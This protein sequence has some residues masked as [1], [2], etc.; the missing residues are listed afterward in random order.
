M[1]QD[2]DQRPATSHSAAPPA[3]GA[4]VLYGAAVGAAGAAAA[5]LLDGLLSVSRASQFVAGFGIV[6]FVSYVL[7]AYALVGAIV[8]LVAASAVTGLMRWTSLG[9]AVK[10]LTTA[11]AHRRSTDPNRVVAATAVGFTFI[12]ALG[13]CVLL[14][15][16]VVMPFVA[17]RKSIQL[18]VLIVIGATVFACLVAIPLTLVLARVVERPLTWASRW[19]RVGRLVSHLSTPWLMYGALML[20]AVAGW[21]IRAA[22]QPAAQ[23]VRGP[24]LVLVSA[25]VVGY[26]IA[27]PLRRIVR[28]STA[29][30]SWHTA[31]SVGVGIAILYGGLFGLGASSSVIKAQSTYSALGMRITRLARKPFDFDRDG[32]ASVLGGGDC[33]DRDPSVHPGAV[34]V[35]GDSVDQNCIGGDAVA[36]APLLNPQGPQF[37]VLPP[38]VPRDARILLITV[39]T[40]RADHLGAYGYARATSPN[41]DQLGAQGTVF[42]NAWAHAP[43]TY[44]SMPA[45]LTGRMP[46]RVA[47]GA[48]LDGSAIVAP[49]AH[50]IAESLHPLGFTTGAIVNLPY[51]DRARGLDQGFDDY[52]NENAALNAHIGVGNAIGSSSAEQTAKALAF[53]DKY[54]DRKW[55]LWVHYFDPHFQYVRHPGPAP[56]GSRPIDLYDGEIRYTDAAIGKLLSGLRDRGLSEK[57]AVI[58]TSDHGESFGD[59]GELFHGGQLY[60]PQAKIP[61]L[62]RVPGLAPRRSTT[63]VGHIDILPTIVNLAGGVPTAD[64][65]GQSMLG[66]MMGPD[67]QKIV[68]QQLTLKGL[69]QRRGA[70]SENCHVIYSRLPDVSWEVYRTDR[71]PLERHDLSDTDECASTRQALATWCND[72]D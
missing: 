39:D 67:Q 60:A 65:M 1:N 24:V 11:H 57:T 31:L 47:V 59:H 69:R 18:V 43:A 21:T 42:S 49:A 17:G 38:S 37:A 22:D 46:L 54:Q 20:T 72:C 45:I 33:N 2:L 68:Y 10:L 16:R 26:F 12:P 66:A 32:Y 28:W 3:F 50:T 23:V 19:H 52:D 9:D 41:L 51:F 7:V 8:G 35:P 25:I 6:R 61:L 48:Q 5:G 29:R 70:V 44:F 58:V 40:T 15:L 55:F 27:T 30:K 13:I 53:V 34:D 71:D 4:W 63:P 62:M 64:M 56:F 14:M 36:I